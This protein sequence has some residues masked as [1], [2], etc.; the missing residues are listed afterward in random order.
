MKNLTPFTKIAIANSLLLI[1]VFIF[2]YF[3][4]HDDAFI[5]TGLA[6]MIFCVLE[7][8]IGIIIAIASKSQSV[9]IKYGQ[10]FMLISV[11][12]LLSSFTLCSQGNIL[13]F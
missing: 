7:L 3:T 9:E 12:L 11:F 1:I 6:A 8:I 2:T 10:A 13:N 5:T 4:S